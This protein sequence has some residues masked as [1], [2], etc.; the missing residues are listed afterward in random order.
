MII[1]IALG[2]LLT[3]IAGVYALIEDDLYQWFNITGWIGLGLCGIAG[4]M[5]DGLSQPE[6]NRERSASQGIGFV[7]TLWLLG[8]PSLLTSLLLYIL[9]YR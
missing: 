8:A 6:Y 7:A 9:V 5:S 2:L 1:R 3:A 4:L